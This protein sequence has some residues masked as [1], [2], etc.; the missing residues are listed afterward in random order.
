MDLLDDRI[1]TARL[2]GA[3]ND[4]VLHG[5]GNVSVKTME[6]DHA[7]RIIKVLRVKGSGS[8]MSSLERDNLTGLRMEDILHAREKD[9]MTDQEMMDYLKRSM[10]NPS[11][12]SPSVESFLHGFIP[13]TYV[14]HTHS[15]HILMLTNTEM[16]NDEIKKILG[17]VLIVD[18]IRPGFTLAREVLKKIENITPDVEGIVL[19]KHGL[20]TFG[21]T[22]QESYDRHMR[23]VGRAKDYI[24]KTIGFNFYTEKYEKDPEMKNK[25]IEVRGACS[26]IFSKAVLIDCSDE[27]LKIA[28]SEEAE[29]YEHSGPATPDMLIRT[30][31]EYVFLKKEDDVKKVM[32]DFAQRYM[33]EQKKYA[34]LYPPHDPY[35][36]A[37]ILSGYGIMTMARD[38]GTC[39]I[40]RDQIIHSIRV[41]SIAGKISR[42]SFISKKEAY[43]M[44]YW[45]LE[46]AKLKNFKP[47]TLQGKIS[48]VTGAASGIGLASAE[49]LASNGSI[50]VCAD[51]DP[52]VNEVAKNIEKKTGTRC[53]PY[54]IDLSKVQEIDKM[55]DF[56]IYD[57]GGIDIVFN[58]A[59]ILKSEFIEDISMETINRHIDIN[60]RAPFRISQLAFIA[61][62][63]QGIGGN[64]VFNITKNL[65]HPGPGMASYGTTK[66]F[67][68]QLSHYI[69][70]EGG[71]YGIRSNII[72]PDKIF[73]NSKIWENGV[74]ESRAKAKGITEEEYK[75]GNLLRKEVLPEHVA[76]VLIALVTE[77]IFGCTTDA[78]IPVDGG[79]I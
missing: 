22:A 58:N 30:K 38:Y 17:N 27:A 13:Y 46:E 18:Y 70:K 12:A 9:S 66:A 61:M 50:V 53:I 28:R 39:G 20:F 33:E 26:K 44:E 52:K 37:V 56:I 67:A 69:A 64:F 77:E 7:G 23:I 71:K 21:E 62:K 74:L 36:A 1:R 47:R 19:R 11:E 76:N 54:L 68:A 48:L 60:S 43:E 65:T 31:Y 35:P 8:D 63:K 6:E 73:K 72:N 2:L 34:S 10:V 51:L 3:D 59:G 32:E 15:D 41:N 42:H 79:I 24:K 29:K 75:K 45:P 14:D 5:G 25:I 78:M 57:V 55:M 4:L 40:I 49:A 16:G